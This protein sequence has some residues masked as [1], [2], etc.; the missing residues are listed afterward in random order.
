MLISMRTTAGGKVP[1]STYLYP[2]EAEAL[3]RAAE[4]ERLPKA[5]VVRRAV[6]E[7]LERREREPAK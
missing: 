7:W 5:E 2:D 1:V 3:E 4:E 6:R